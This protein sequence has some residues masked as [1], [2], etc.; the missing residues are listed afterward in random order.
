MTDWKNPHT[1]EEAGSLV[2]HLPSKFQGPGTKTEQNTLILVGV[3]CYLK[4]PEVCSPLISA[5]R[6]QSSMSS[7]LAWGEGR[8]R[9]GGGKI[10][11]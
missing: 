1:T 5:L 6:R 9:E 4:D 8:R 10:D 11:R 2:E 7:R 3:I